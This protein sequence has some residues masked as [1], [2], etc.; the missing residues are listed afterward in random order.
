MQKWEYLTIRLGGVERWSTV[1]AFAWFVNDQEVKNWKKISIHT[2]IS[3]LGQDG[4]EM[5]G[6]LSS[7]GGYL[8]FKRPKT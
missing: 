2:F 8:F 7:H 6:A 4:W 3:E 1:D 5:T